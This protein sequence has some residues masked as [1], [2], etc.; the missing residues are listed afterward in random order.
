MVDLSIEI[1]DLPEGKPTYI[2]YPIKSQ[3]N[4]IKSPLN[5]IK[6]TIKSPLNHHFL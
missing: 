3:L 6:I 1:V 4:P 2:I 5:P